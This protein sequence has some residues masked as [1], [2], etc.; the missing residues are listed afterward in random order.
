[1][2]WTEI[3]IGTF[4][5]HWNFIL[6]VKLFT[7]KVKTH[8]LKRLKFVQTEVKRSTYTDWE[9]FQI[10]MKQLLKVCLPCVVSVKVWFPIAQ[11]SSSYS[12][13]QK[14]LC[15]FLHG[16]PNF[17]RRILRALYLAIPVRRWSLRHS[18]LYLFWNYTWNAIFQRFLKDI[19]FT[20]AIRISEKNTQRL[21]QQSF[22]FRTF[23]QAGRKRL[24]KL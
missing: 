21:Q 14:Y 18:K 8:D 6:Y 1:M 11:T 7:E 4:P 13:S 16:G 24:S 19:L 23:H 15:S 9:S 5:N 2:H 22:F 17:F 3:S 10:C 12:N 20:L